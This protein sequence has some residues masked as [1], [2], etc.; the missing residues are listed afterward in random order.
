ME[1]ITNGKFVEVAYKIF[2]VGKDG[3]TMIYEFKES[4]PDKFVIG[5]EPGLLESFT[6][7]LK[8]LKAGEEFDI[9]LSPAE[10][11]GERKADWVQTIDKQIFVID[12]EFDSDRV[13][14][15]AQVP[16]MTAD[17][18]RIEGLVTEITDT[19]VTLDFNHP[20]AGE[21]MRYLGK[22]I[23]VRDATE[24]EKNPPRQCGGCGGGDCGGCGEGG[25]DK[26]GGCEKGC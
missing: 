9:T 15:G 22:V 20:F 18:M 7:R 23:S 26:E 11:F 2:L 24:E 14:E 13:K 17:G 10:A 4:N 25:C 8:G 19:T 5:Y 21:T 1:I 16:M 12:G 3:D 6:D